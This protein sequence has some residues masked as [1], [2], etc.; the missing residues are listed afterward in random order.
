MPAM[1]C[2]PVPRPNRWRLG[3]IVIC[4]SVV[5]ILH[6]FLFS[7]LTTT[8]HQPRNVLLAM[9]SAQPLPGQ[10]AAADVRALIPGAAVER[11]LEGGRSHTYEVALNAGQFIEIVV[12]QQGLDVVVTMNGADGEQLAE[13]DG[14]NAMHGPERLAHIAEVTGIYKLVVRPYRDTAPL[15]RYQLRIEELRE[16]A[17]TDRIR[18][19]A[20]KRLI[21]GQQL[22]RNRTADSLRAALPRFEESLSLWT[23]LE[24]RQGKADA[25]WYLADTYI[26]IQEPRKA[27]DVLDK[28]LAL[29]RALADVRGEAIALQH[30]ASNYRV[31]SEYQKALEYQTRALH[32]ARTIENY[33]ELGSFLD[34]MGSIYFRLGEH[35]R[36]LE[37]FEQA[38][39]IHRAHG[40]R[41]LEAIRLWQIGTVHQSVG[42]RQQ[43]LSYF[44]KALAITR[45][46]P[47]PRQQANILSSMGAVYNSQGDPHRAIEHF[48]QSI[49]LSRKSGFRYAEATTLSSL[50]DAY[51]SLGETEKA[52]DVLGQ[53]LAIQR[54]I[55]DREFEAVTLAGLARAES[56]RGNLT[57]ARQHLET[58]LEI[59]ESLRSN[60]TQEGLRAAYLGS[61]EV[62]YKLYVDLL[63]RLHAE[64]PSATEDAAAL[65]ASE[66][67]R[68]RSLLEILTEAR[69]DI[70]SGVDADLLQ[71]ERRLQ[72]LINTRAER[73]VQL[74]SAKRTQEAE[75]VGKELDTL[76]TEYRQVQ[77][78]IRASSPRY[79][80]VTQP[81]PL[82]VREIQREVLDRDSLLLEYSLGAERSY[83][84][85]VTT[86]GLT[87]H[88]LPK[89]AEIEALVRRLYD[90]LTARNLRPVGE[91]LERRAAR[92]NQAEAEYWKVAD[93]LSQMLLGP[94][95]TELGT[96]RLIIVSD[97]ALQ[98]VPFSALPAPQTVASTQDEKQNLS[99][100][101]P[102]ATRV[103]QGANAYRPLIVD[104]EI[105]A[106][107]SAS[108]LHVLRR[109][110]GGR[111][112][113]P[114]S[115]AVLADPVFS[116]DDPRL[117]RNRRGPAKQTDPQ[118][119]QV[120]DHSSS[121]VE[122]SAKESGVT[123]FRRLRFSRQ[124]AEAVTALARAN[125]ALKATDF[126]ASRAT[127]TG[128]QLSGYRIVHFATHGL[129]NNHNPELSGIVL[130]L[131][132]Q[133]G[134]PQD[135]FLRLHDVYNLRLGAELVVLSACQTALGRE[136]K[137]EGL[138]GL[139]RG[140]MYA[141]A[142]R[143]LASLWNV[144]DRATAELMKQLY[145]GVLR[146]GEPP[147]AALRAAQ[148]AMWN[149][150]LWQSPYYWA[151]FVMQG[152]WR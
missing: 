85:A 117:Q 5:L 10:V 126:A 41:D 144:D 12:N 97:G 83:V 96:K 47:M 24:D 118:Q 28:L 27:L 52:L 86:D 20:Q 81:R 98:Y 146:Q 4:F 19:D 99:A 7:P 80:A 15:G 149:S 2:R 25:F 134:Q 8:S 38:L 66:R 90:L 125:D 14:P 61:K 73:Q 74:L 60:V 29:R 44:E 77:G 140:F 104:H 53:A 145:V 59:V 120:E 46:L 88:V 100:Q 114:K 51:V 101:Q 1:N 131:V 35:R 57:M 69:A 148:V 127:A 152:E 141:G 150:R 63:M 49:G 76:V 84:W 130:S 13:V 17:A 48:Q 9:P 3:S 132:D 142:P 137:G 147:A 32:L 112:P 31:L 30:I 136:V 33:E 78:E 139:T 42:E 56:G 50:G 54:A 36:A 18:L 110:L 22:W 26:A 43:A 129:L 70:R 122:R 107:P 121:E 116:R 135:G 55:R 65:E 72:D 11:Q 111:P 95:A 37:Y 39:P 119:S 45:T 138:I 115:V 6:H 91:T 105:V 16:A 62:P 34:H 40:F 89:R 151:A 21:E 75:V 94:V 143:V 103:S 87:S 68:A 109:E 92:L 124:E 93:G 128:P 23:T 64:R 82:S 106:L 133:A 123:V 79:A 108:V 71:R 58:A 102:A 67:W 113:A